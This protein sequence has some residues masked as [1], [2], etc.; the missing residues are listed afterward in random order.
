M[1]F[2]NFDASR[3]GTLPGA[4]S[5]SSVTHQL[6]QVME[7]RRI[8]L[9]GGVH[10]H[11]DRTGCCTDVSA[12]R[13]VG[14]LCGLSVATGADLVAARELAMSLIGGDIAT[15]ETM[16]DVHAA[17]GAAIL[18]YREAS[19]LTGVVGIIRCSESQVDEIQRG[20][21][22]GRTIAPETLPKPGQPAAGVYIWAAAGST[23]QAKKAVL[24][25]AS[26][27]IGTLMWALPIYSRAATSDGL[28]ALTSFGFRPLPSN[29][30]FMGR[31]PMGKALQSRRTEVL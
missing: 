13:K 26:H 12:I 24:L 29:A 10:E 31:H 7:E 4:Y 11:V 8:T 16:R 5:L 15:F 28:R 14:E 20:S 3:K 6:S 30:E 2:R 22:D 18:V 9:V 27:V 23:R 19:R 17:A 1:V 25:G 21:F